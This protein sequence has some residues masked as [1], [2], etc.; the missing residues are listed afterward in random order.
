MTGVVHQPAQELGE[1]TLNVTM[2]IEHTVIWGGPAYQEET[3]IENV[4]LG[5]FGSSTLTE[6]ELTSNV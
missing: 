5:A 2:D 3:V 1:E 4:A 6:G